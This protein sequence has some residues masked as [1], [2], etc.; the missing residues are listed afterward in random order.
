[1]FK[2][3]QILILF[4]MLLLTGIAVFAQLSID[5]ETEKIMPFVTNKKICMDC[6]AQKQPNV[7]NEPYKACDTYCLTCH[8]DMSVKHHPSGIRMRKIPEAIEL[9][10]TQRMACISCH[11]LAE[12]RFDTSPWRSQSLYDSLFS[13][14]KHHTYYLKVKNTNGELCLRCHNRAGEK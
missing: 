2:R 14:K 9:T 4:V 13:S 12:K 10:S 5:L 7:V 11:N 3:Q 6:H 8:N 1:M